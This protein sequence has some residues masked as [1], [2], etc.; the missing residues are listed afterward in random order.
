MTK[1]WP[2]GEMLVTVDGN[3]QVRSDGRTVWVETFVGTV[4]RFCPMSQEYMPVPNGRVTTIA[5][6]SEPSLNNWERFVQEVKNRFG[7]TIE[8]QHLPAYLKGL[9]T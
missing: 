2:T 4:A 1:H 6:E 7:I 9:N 8:T 3:R 5:H